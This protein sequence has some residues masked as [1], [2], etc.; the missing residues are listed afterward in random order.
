MG[1]TALPAALLFV[2]GNLHKMCPLMGASK[3]SL[4]KLLVCQHKNPFRVIKTWETS[5]TAL[6]WDP[7]DCVIR[8]R[9]T[10]ITNR[11]ISSDKIRTGSFLPSPW[12]NS[13][14]DYFKSYWSLSHIFN[15]YQS[16]L[17]F[18][19]IEVNPLLFT[20][21][22]STL[23]CSSESLLFMICTIGRQLEGTRNSPWKNNIVP[24]QDSKARNTDS[25][26]CSCQTRSMLKDQR[27]L[28]RFVKSGFWCA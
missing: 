28:V 14:S 24:T 7:Q 20:F 16:G 21:M 23:P 26:I 11:W 15:L 4:I 3:T 19:F 17:Y 13:R 5:V 12:T 9:R 2:P 6:V 25:H 10:A 18:H 1:H 22:S 27:G 8:A